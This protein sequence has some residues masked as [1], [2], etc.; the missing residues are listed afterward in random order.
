[1]KNFKKVSIISLAIL[2]IFNLASPISVSAA[3]T[4]SLGSANSFAILSS[5]FTSSLGT[6][7]ITGD[8]GYTTLSGAGTNT[9]NGTTHVADAKYNQAGIDQSAALTNLASQNCTY[10]FPDGPIDLAA[11]TTHGPIGVYTPGVYCT[12]GAA[13]VGTAGITLNGLGTYIFRINGALT[14]VANSK[15]TLNGASA[16]DTFWLPT[17]AATL[18]ADT[19]F[20]GTIIDASGITVGANT[21]WSGKALAFGATVT[22]DADTISSPTC[23]IIVPIIISAPVVTP[24]S[25]PVLTTPTIVTPISA[26]IVIQAEVPVLTTSV[27]TPKLPNTGITSS[28]STPWNVIIPVGLLITLLSLYLVRKK[29]ANLV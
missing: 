27:V 20:S 16:C 22:T 17:A 5:T 8:L 9:I 4:P 15:V 28:N 2:F 13:S 12:S 11:D 26:P 7:V 21:T 6:T 3:T 23:T 1:M 24:T 29:I 14:T 18:G 19:N 25:T 10:T